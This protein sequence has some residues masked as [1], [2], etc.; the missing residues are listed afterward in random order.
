MICSGSR[1]KNISNARALISY[2]ASE[3]VGHSL[4]DVARV[5]GVK[6]VSVRE[7]VPKGKIIISNYPLLM[8]D[9]K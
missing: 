2:I 4:S 7:A 8:S 3:I 6:R 5:L 1:L 9:I